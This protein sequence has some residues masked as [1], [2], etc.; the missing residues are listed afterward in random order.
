M[1]CLNFCLFYS[2]KN[3]TGK[4]ELKQDQILILT[5]C[6]HSAKKF[7]YQYSDDLVSSVRAL[8]NPVGLSYLENK[9]VE[10]CVAKVR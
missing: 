9:I 2:I 1:N 4:L 7:A 10:I 5:P 3:K 6:I 8:Q